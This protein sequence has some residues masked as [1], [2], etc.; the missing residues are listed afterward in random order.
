MIEL[1]AGMAVSVFLLFY[2]AFNLN[3]EEHFFLKLL[4]IGFAMSA[5][6]LIAKAPLGNSCAAEVNST[7]T[8]GNLT[9]Y[10]YAQVCVKATSDNT[11]LIFYKLILWVNRLF[12]VYVLVYT[13]IY[14]INRYLNKKKGN[15]E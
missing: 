13:T 10:T 4:L 2:F 8:A 1:I 6:L 9:T 14:F 5:I 12:W 11:A 15:N 3:E 7:V